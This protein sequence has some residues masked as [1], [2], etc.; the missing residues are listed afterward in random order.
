MKDNPNYVDCEV[1][2]GTYGEPKLFFRNAG[3]LRIGKFCSIAHDVRIFLGGEHRIDWTTTYPFSALVP[4]F[5][6]I[7]GHPRS[8][9]GVTIGN[10]VW[11]AAGAVILSGVTISDGAVIGAYSVVTRDVP[12]YTVVAGN[13][14][15]VV[16]ARFTEHQVQALLNIAWWNW[17]INRIYDAMPMLLSDNIQAFIDLHDPTIK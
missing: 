11:I 17:P 5:A 16:R 2:E 8:K 15:R 3:T 10:D 12:A 9:G 4:E 7:P 6:A 13:P 1:G 14:A